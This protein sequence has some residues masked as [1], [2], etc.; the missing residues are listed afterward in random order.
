VRTLRKYAEAGLARYWIIDPD[1]PE[2]VVFERS[3][4]GTLVEAARYRGSEPA[5]LDV[6]PVPFR[7]TAGE[8]LSRHP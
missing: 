8:L 2:I 3:E 1:G 7:L 5:D 6:G 4:S